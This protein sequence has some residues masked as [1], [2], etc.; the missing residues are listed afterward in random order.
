MEIN[1]EIVTILRQ[2]KMDKD[3]GILALLAI[4]FNLNPD[5]IVPEEIVKGINLTKI[6]DKDYKRNT[7]VWNVPLFMGQ[8]TEWEWVEEWNKKWN[9]NPARKDSN[10]DVRR[11]MQEFFKK[12]PHIRI[13]DIRKATD[14]YFRNLT[15]PQYLMGSAKFIFDGVGAAKKST[16]LAWCEK[17]LT[18]TTPTGENSGQKGTIIK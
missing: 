11:R 9:V 17:I 13:E 12:Y 6:I 14:L 4:Y 8:Q 7:I 18:S 3:T 16:L 15:S 5:Y 1:P 10:P 2:H